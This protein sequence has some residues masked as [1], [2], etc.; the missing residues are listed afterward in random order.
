MA[1]SYCSTKI[2]PIVP[3]HLMRYFV[4]YF[5]V[6]YL[7]FFFNRARKI[8][9]KILKMRRQYGSLFNFSEREKTKTVYR[10]P[11]PSH[12][13]F[14]LKSAACARVCLFICTC[15]WARRR[16][17]GLRVHTEISRKPT[18]TVYHYI[19][20]RVRLNET[21]KHDDQ[22]LSRAHG[23][24]ACTSDVRK[25]QGKHTHCVR[26]ARVFGSLAMQNLIS[27]PPP[28]MFYNRGN[29]GGNDRIAPNEPPPSYAP[30][31]D[32][33]TVSLD[34][35]RTRAP[36]SGVCFAENFVRGLRASFVY[37]CARRCGVVLA[38]RHTRTCAFGR[39][40]LLAAHV[41]PTSYGVRTHERFEFARPSVD[42]SSVRPKLPYRSVSHYC[43]HVQRADDAARV[44]KSKNRKI[45]FLPVEFSVLDLFHFSAAPINRS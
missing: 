32:A 15:F 29:G 3:S 9:S 36:V 20:R 33:R 27:S 5:P 14:N 44:G 8:N 2:S 31:R 22:T 1:F 34:A 41:F 40:A 7:F 37:T 28:P 17:N 30:H 4:L 13:K 18:T 23:R 10:P 19:Y 39:Q 26:G 42:S 24:R 11:P 45:A 35:A 6:N 16:R 25:T 21:G 43:L 38:K 12:W